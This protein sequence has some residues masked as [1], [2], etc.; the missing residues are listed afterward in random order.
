MA[1]EYATRDSVL[2]LRR[3]FARIAARGC[4]RFGCLPSAVAEYR[5]RFRRHSAVHI[6][7]DGRTRIGYRSDIARAGDVMADCH[8]DLLRAPCRGWPCGTRSA[9]AC[10]GRCS[11]FRVPQRIRTN[12]PDVRERHRIRRQ[13]EGAGRAA[14]W[15]SALLSVATDSIF[16]PTELRPESEF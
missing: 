12:Q 6:R 1:R 9:R 2:A 3:S 11:G 7:Y 8:H 14:G 16:F 5:H 4:R 13:V 15:I 10:G